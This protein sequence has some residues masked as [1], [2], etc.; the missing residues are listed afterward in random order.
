MR[1]LSEIKGRTDLIVPV[2][3]LYDLRAK[4][5]SKQAALSE[6]EIKQL[7]TE[8]FRTEV[9]IRIIIEDECADWEKLLEILRDAGCHRSGILKLFFSS[10]FGVSV[11]DYFSGSTTK[12]LTADVT[13]VDM[14]QFV[15]QEIFSRD[16]PRRLLKGQHPQLEEMLVSALLKQAGGM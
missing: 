2:T 1:Q 16:L 4:D 9:D 12:I 5:R 14:K 13:E 7:L 11:E 6:K 10:R 8:I 15:H 3:R